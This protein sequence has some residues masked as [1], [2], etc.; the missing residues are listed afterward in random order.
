MFTTTH[1]HLSVDRLKRPRGIRAV[2]VFVFVSSIAGIAAA[3]A[4]W[5]IFPSPSPAP[6]ARLNGTAVL[7]T[8][9]AW[10]V[11]QNSAYSTS[12]KALILRFNGTSWSQFAVPDS[13]QY[14]EGLNDV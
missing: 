13:T 6:D 7:A 5:T 4:G 11:G 8:N 9:N 3:A 14:D 12:D 1:A 2:A 10:A